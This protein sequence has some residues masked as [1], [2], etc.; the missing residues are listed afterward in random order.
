MDPRCREALKNWE[1]TAF[2]PCPS[3][4]DHLG[5]NLRRRS[6]Q[7]SVR[8]A[9]EVRRAKAES[10]DAEHEHQRRKCDVEAVASTDPGCDRQS[11]RS[12]CRSVRR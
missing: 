4:P 6:T 1:A 5:P 8:G 3:R 7:H 9:K 12:A 11:E 10:D 2:G